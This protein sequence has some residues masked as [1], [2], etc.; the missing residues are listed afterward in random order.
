LEQDVER[1]VYLKKKA[2]LMSE[3][4]SL[5]EKTITLEQKRTGWVEPMRKWIKQAET[6][7]KIARDSNLFGKKVAAKEIFGSNLLLA[8][9][10]ARIGA[11]E[12]G[13]NAPQNWGQTQW[14]AMQAAHQMASEKPTSFVLVAPRGIPRR[15]APCP[16]QRQRQAIGVADAPASPVGLPLLLPVRFP[17]NK[18]KHH[19]RW[20]VCL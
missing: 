14:A 18:Q 19:T 16:G 6:L 3:K 10:E 17:L 8:G 2:E 5:E 13:A 12:G 1:E 9:K 20:C 11:P 15:F 4:K 7:P